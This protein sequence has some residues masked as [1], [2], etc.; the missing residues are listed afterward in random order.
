[1]KPIIEREWNSTTRAME[2]QC[3]LHWNLNRNAK[4]LKRKEA[5]NSSVGGWA[6]PPFGLSTRTSLTCPRRSFPLA[7]LGSPGRLAACSNNA[8]C[9][10]ACI[11]LKAPLQSRA[12]AKWAPAPRPLQP[13][14]SLQLVCNCCGNMY[15][16]SLMILAPSWGSTQKGTEQW[17]VIVL[18]CAQQDAFL[19]QLSGPLQS[20]PGFG[21]WLDEW[22]SAVVYSLSPTKCCSCCQ[23]SPLQLLKKN[24]GIGKRKAAAPEHSLYNNLNKGSRGGVECP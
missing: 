22:S 12:P 9:S 11:R 3:I 16:L 20:P 18:K 2:R 19:G 13:A 4:L 1:M 15:F 5:R 23:P 6:V 8:G 21:A 7:H 24:K 14:D 17:D 10:F